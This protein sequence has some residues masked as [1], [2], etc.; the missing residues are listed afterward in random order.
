M[1]GWAGEKSKR[2]EGE[3]STRQERRV[4]VHG[5]LAERLLQAL[6]ESSSPVVITSGDHIGLS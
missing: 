3:D 2:H 1:I 4:G 6:P 5:S